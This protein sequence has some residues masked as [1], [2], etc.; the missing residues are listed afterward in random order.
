MIIPV[1]SRK[2]G[3]SGVRVYKARFEACGLLCLAGLGHSQ[4]SDLRSQLS[5]L[6]SQI[7][8]LSSQ[9]S[10]QSPQILDLCRSQLSDS[11]LSRSQIWAQGS[12]IS[13]Q[14]SQ[15]SALI[16]QISDLSSQISALSSQIWAQSSQIS[17]LTSNWFRNFYKHFNSIYWFCIWFTDAS[18]IFS[19]FESLYCAVLEQGKSVNSNTNSSSFANVYYQQFAVSY[20]TTDCSTV[21]A[22]RSNDFFT[23][24][25]AIPKINNSFNSGTNYCKLNQHVVKQI[26]SL[27]VNL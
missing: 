15:I 2:S 26:T 23:R 3:R 11:D 12:Q 20:E 21:F 18:L 27:N 24:P 7:S 1:G 22:A 13:A 25:N 10:A 14:G 17:G 9:V 5:D 19:L 8:A 6:R 4:L 16:S